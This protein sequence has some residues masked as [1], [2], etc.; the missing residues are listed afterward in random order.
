MFYPRF[1]TGSQ[2]LW[3]NMISLMGHVPTPGP[4]NHSGHMHM[5]L[6]LTSPRSPCSQW[7]ENWVEAPRAFYGMS[8]RGEEGPHR[9]EWGYQR[10]GESA[11]LNTH[12]HITQLQIP[13]ACLPLRS[14]SNSPG[15][16]SGSVP[17][18]P[19]EYGGSD[20]VEFTVQRGKKQA[21][22]LSLGM[23]TLGSQ[24]HCYKE[25][26]GEAPEGTKQSLRPSCPAELPVNSQE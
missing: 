22:P 9:E 20:A 17:S 4:I 8:G 10:R 7:T 13:S 15:L 16:E 26:C 21:A 2:S 14:R 6:L 25:V 1:F 12:I 3:R 24:P 18:W 23:L 5:V 11:T 19:T